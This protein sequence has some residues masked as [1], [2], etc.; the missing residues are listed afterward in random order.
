MAGGGR[1]DID[2]CKIVCRICR[3]GAAAVTV[4]DASAADWRAKRASG[5]RY[6]NNITAADG[7]AL[8]LTTSRRG[9]GG[10]QESHQQINVPA[11]AV[12]RLC[13]CVCVCT[14]CKLTHTHANREAFVVHRTTVPVM[15][16]YSI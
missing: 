14:K 15:I 13:V 5:R 12:I 4:A 16:V 2:S 6:N 1:G 7:C 3:A 9:G 8:V 10:G 11:T